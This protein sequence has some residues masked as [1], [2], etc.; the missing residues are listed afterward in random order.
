M[1]TCLEKPRSADITVRGR[2]AAAIQSTS[3]EQASMIVPETGVSST[4]PV[5]PRGF[6]LGRFLA[7][8]LLA[9]LGMALILVIGVGLLFIRRMNAETAMAIVG[10][11]V[12]A[13]IMCLGGGFGLMATAAA[14][15]D[16]Q[17]FDRL[18]SGES[19]PEI[20]TGLGDN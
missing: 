5:P 3:S 8:F 16:E 17:E 6:R 11:V 10:V 1:I 7:G 9:G 4:T 15:Y 19:S 18:M 20:Q 14:G 2:T 12:L 13:G